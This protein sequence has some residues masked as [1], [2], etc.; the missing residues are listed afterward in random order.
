VKVVIAVEEQ[1]ADM[2]PEDSKAV[3]KEG[4]MG[5]ATIHI[6]QGTSTTMAA[7]GSKLEGYTD[8]GIMG[9]FAEKGGA[10]VDQVTVLMDNL[11]GTVTKLDETV[12]QVN[13]I[14]DDNREGIQQIVTNLETLSSD[15]NAIINNSKGDI[16]TLTRDLSAFTTMLKENTDSIESMLENLDHLSGDLANSDIINNID[17]TVASLNATIENL[18]GIIATIES[19]EGDTLGEGVEVGHIIHRYGYELILEAHEDGAQR[20]VVGRGYHRLHTLGGGCTLGGGQTLKLVEGACEVL[21]LEGLEEVVDA[22][23]LEGL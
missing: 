21:L 22:I 1:Y 4:M 11:N 7:D 6:E 14:L 2:I 3:I 12:S 13:G 18:N 8:G 5:G 17:A 16:K 20:V 10:I 23:Y 19:G 15:I 9:M